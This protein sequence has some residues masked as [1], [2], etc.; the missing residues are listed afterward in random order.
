MRRRLTAVGVS[1]VA[2]AALV[3]SGAL[4][5]AAPKAA[6][7][8]P[9]PLSVVANHFVASGH[10]IQLDG[11]SHSGTEYACA[12][13]WG[14]FDGDLTNSV[15]TTMTTWHPRIVRIPL[16]EDCWLGING[17][18]PQYGGANYRSAILGVVHRLESHGLYV[19]LDLHVGAP[20]TKLATTQEPMADA[21]HSP[22]FWT[23]VA[24]T[25]KNDRDVTFELFNEPFRTSWSCWLK[26]C[27]EHGYKTAGMQQL[28]NAVRFTGARNVLLVAGISWSNDLSGWLAHE[29][30]DPGHQ[31]AAVNHVYDNGGCQTRTCWNGAFAH[32]ARHVPLITT[33]FGDLE[34]NGVFVDKYMRWTDAHGVSYLA[35]TWNPWSCTG[36]PA[37]IKSYD[38]TPSGLGKDIRAHFRRRF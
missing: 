13:G 5:N 6:A 30:E 36:S 19:D 20:G 33:E 32:V 21:D 7:H 34:C 11:F 24:Q 25:F 2:T 14:I 18:K 27:T 26:G 31:L 15:I 28:V 12:Q 23:S 38:G 4:A 16:N 29:P 1:L 22:A 17:V 3:L 10:A 37:I 35:W 9:A 8:A